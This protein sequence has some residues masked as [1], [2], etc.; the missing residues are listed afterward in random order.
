ME[1]QYRSA[2]NVRVWPLCDAI[3]LKQLS[4]YLDRL[5]CARSGRK[6]TSLCSK[7]PNKSYKG[8]NL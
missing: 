5:S 2:R 3:D 6:I 7:S 4:M 1:H 8:F